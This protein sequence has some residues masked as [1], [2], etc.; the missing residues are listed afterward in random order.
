MTYFIRNK[1]NQT[2]IDVDVW[3][4]LTT[5]KTVTSTNMLNCLR[6]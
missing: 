1:Q 4:K 2:I 5:R 3:I 6:L